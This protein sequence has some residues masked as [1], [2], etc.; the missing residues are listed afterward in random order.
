MGYLAVNSAQSRWVASMVIT[1]H[2]GLCLSRQRD[3]EQL[4][5]VLSHG[6]WIGAAKLSLELTPPVFLVFGH[7]A[8]SPQLALGEVDEKVGVLLYRDVVMHGVVLT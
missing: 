1:K 7:A 8:L 4:G 3:S 5:H 2:R 6:L